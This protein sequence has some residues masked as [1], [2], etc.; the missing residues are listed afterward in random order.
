MGNPCEDSFPP[1]QD[2][3]TAFWQIPHSVLAAALGVQIG[4]RREHDFTHSKPARFLLPGLWL[5]VVSV[6]IL[7]GIVQLL[8]LAPE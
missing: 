2:K 6:A 4:P 3:T 5:T 7:L 8:Y 1:S